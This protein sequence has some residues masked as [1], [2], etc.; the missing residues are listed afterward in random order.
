V[1]RLALALVAGL[2]LAGPAWALDRSD[3]RFERTLS[4]SG[5]SPIAF[6]PDGRMYAHGLTSFADLRILD[7]SSNQVPWRTLPEPRA[8]RPAAV[9]VLNSGRQGNAA[10]ALL[11]FGPR[12]QVR[13]RIELTIPDSGFVGRVEVLG[14]DDRETFT[15]LSTSVVYDVEGVEGRARSTVVAFPP[16]DYRY[17]QLRARGVSRIAGATVLRV[18]RR[19]APRR[20]VASVTRTSR[21]PTRLILDLGHANVPVDELDVSSRTRRYDRAARVHGSNDRQLWQP[22]AS[23][24]VFRLGGSAPTQIRVDG[25]HRYLRLTIRNGDDAPLQGIQVEAL[26]RPRPLLVEGGHPLPLLVL[27]GDQRARAP[28]YDFARLPAPRGREQGTL[29]PERRNELFEPPA[30]TRSFAARH[31][32]LVTAALALA[33]L[34]AA[35]GGALALRRRA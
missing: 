13:E 31:T 17:L 9:R 12:R 22:L 18:T 3:F 21:N 34:A 15:R 10:V 1:R 26:A 27:Y 20:L 23:A 24:R 30:D 7:A 2:A 5:G 25:R 11:D 19:S 16:S 29:G 33:A 35:A 32:G 8:P 4:A 6:E 14:S 28:S